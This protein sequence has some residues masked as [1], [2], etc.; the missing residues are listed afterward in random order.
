MILERIKDMRIT[1]KLFP[2]LLLIVFLFSGCSDGVSDDPENDSNAITMYIVGSSPIS[3]VM[4]QYNNE[5]DIIEF[6]NNKELSTKLSAEL[7]ADKG[8]DLIFYDSRYGGVSNI[9][10]MIT[11]DMFEDFNNL[12]NN[13]ESKITINLDDYN[14][15][16]MDSGIYNG[17]RYFMPISYMPNILITTKEICDKYSVDLSKSFTCKELEGMLSEFL[18][19]INT[20]KDKSVFY[21]ISNK[22]C[23]LI[24]LN[25]NFF[26]RTN[27]LS[28]DSFLACLDIL[29][30]LN[31]SNN[32]SYDFSALEY[33]TQGNVMFIALN[34]VTGSEPN[35]IGM[36]YYQIIAE[37]Q[38]PILLSNLSYDGK[39]CSAFF[40]KG[41]FINKNSDKKEE[42]YE[43]VKYMLSEEVQKNTEIGLPVNKNAQ[44][45][46]INEMSEMSAASLGVE[47][48][49]NS[50]AQVS[51]DYIKSYT[52]ILENISSCRFSNNYFNSSIIG[53]TVSNYIAGDITR[54]Q[55][56]KQLQ[57]KSKIYL[58]E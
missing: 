14:K 18:N 13:D 55:F 19:E 17:K 28:S 52:N 25:I 56:I 23:E 36:I 9:E 33:L 27:T 22:Y 40:D 51:S 42:A 11:Q 49:D 8:P 24:N 15:A 57:D 35:G 44:S 16:V 29:D 45:K 37:N 31:F 50:E 21:D 2:I 12:I 39:S 4:K 34:D 47:I 1:K 53:D 32:L 30:K 3:S 38:T 7:M 26:D 6:E 10:K 48:T 5:I 46:L 41:F 54:E 20:S 43:F 58:D